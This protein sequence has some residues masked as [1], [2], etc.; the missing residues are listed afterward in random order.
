M[1]VKS[2]LNLTLKQTRTEALIWATDLASGQPVPDLPVSLYAGA[3]LLEAVVRTGADGL[4]A[5]DDLTLGDLWDPFFAMAG[6]PGDEGFGIA[7]NRWEEGLNPWDFDVNSEFW[8]SDYQ[9]YLYT[10]RPI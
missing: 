3:D 8:G 7:Y 1:F 4:A 6:E 10:D 9:G 5:V 2:G